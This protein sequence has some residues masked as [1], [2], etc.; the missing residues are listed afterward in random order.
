MPSNKQQIFEQTKFTYSPLGN[1]FEEQIK[2]IKQHGEK[3]V[4]AIQYKDFNKS[5][6]KSEYGSDDDPMLLKQKYIYNELT[7]EKRDEIKKIG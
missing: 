5:I 3:Q 1:V 7:K 2:K 6:K 4:K